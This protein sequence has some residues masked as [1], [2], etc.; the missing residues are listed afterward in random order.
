M[1]FGYFPGCSAKSTTR[2]CDHATRQVAARLGVEL[3]ELGTA[4]CC[5][6]R[7]LRVSDP[8]FSLTLNARTF[9]LAEQVADELVTIC[10]TCQLNLAQDQLQLR[11]RPELRDRINNQIL[12][13][14][15]LRYEGRLRIRHL[16]WLFAEGYDWG[17]LRR[18][19]VRPLGHLKVAAFPCCHLLRP[20]ELNGYDNPHEPDTL[21]MVIRLFGAETVE[22]G[23]KAS[24]CGFHTLRVDERPAL[25]MAG[26]I[27]QEAKRA[28]AN[29]VVTDSPFCHTVFDVYQSAS[30]DEL[31]LK[32]GIPILHLSQLAGL[33]L[34]ITADDL[35]LSR[36]V[37][38]TGSVVQL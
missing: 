33:A 20:R 25:R 31:R 6:S 27:L 38:P 16:L 32:L 17:K 7:D 34:G 9:A 8:F 22:Y 30:E 1:K 21:D 4:A 10:S 37:V 5:G 18:H 29:C 11:R 2:E 23:G 28:G 36:H 14:F 3:E 15:G 35:L 24:C 26:G 19:I 13:R 12:S